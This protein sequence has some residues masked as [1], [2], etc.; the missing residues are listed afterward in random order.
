MESHLDR[1]LKNLNPI[2]KTILRI[3]FYELLQR[4]DI[5]YKVVINE[6]LELAKT[7]GGSDSYKFTN[8]VLNSASKTLRRDEYQ[9]TSSN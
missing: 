6:A 9:K 4:L 2:E 8:V 3:G 7:F 1:P 5:P